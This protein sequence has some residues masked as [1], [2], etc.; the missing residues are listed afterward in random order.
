MIRKENLHNNPLIVYF[1]NTIKR[2]LIPDAELTTQEQARKEVFEY[3][4]LYCDIKRMHSSLHY[5]ALIEYDKA[6]SS[7]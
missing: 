6:Y 4:E 1:Y 5:L 2:E 7:Y 3:I